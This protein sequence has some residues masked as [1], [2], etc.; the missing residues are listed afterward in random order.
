[1]YTIRQARAALLAALEPLRAQAGA[2]AIETYSG[3]LDGLEDG[4]TQLTVATPALLVAYLGARYS[5][6]EE[7]A[8]EVERR[9]AV[10]ALAKS[11]GPQTARED[12]ATDLLDAARAAL[13]GAALGLE[14]TRPTAVESETLIAAGNGAVAYSMDVLITYRQEMTA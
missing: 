12:Q 14:L 8:D 4:K 10:I 7:G 5:Y 1:M 2:R 11:A 13:H 3:Q 9:F 6:F